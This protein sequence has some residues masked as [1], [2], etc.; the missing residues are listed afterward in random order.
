MFNFECEQSKVLIKDQKSSEEYEIPYTKIDTL[1]YKEKLEGTNT[2]GVIL[3]FVS[4]ILLL[5]VGAA[6]F[7]QKM[8]VIPLEFIIVLSSFFTIGIVLS[9]AAEVK[10]QLKI[11]TQDDRYEFHC[12]REEYKKLFQKV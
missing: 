9:V 11:R 8:W 5:F 3:L 12:N 6:E 2:I 10:T 1:E 4:E 7:S